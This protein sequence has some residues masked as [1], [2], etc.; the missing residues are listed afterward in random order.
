[1]ASEPLIHY[2]LR[3]WHGDFDLCRVTPDGKCLGIDAEIHNRDIVDRIAKAFDA[4][5]ILR[6][7]M[8]A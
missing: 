1:M 3:E 4:T 5:V 6:E 7:M 2:E 8:P